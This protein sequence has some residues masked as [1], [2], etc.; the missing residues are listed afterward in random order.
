MLFVNRRKVWKPLKSYKVEVLGG[1]IPLLH[2]FQT[3]EGPDRKLVRLLS[4]VATFSKQILMSWL[5]PVP[6]ALSLIPSDQYGNYFYI[7]RSFQGFEVS[8]VKIFSLVF[9]KRPLKKKKRRLSMGIFNYFS[10]FLKFYF[11]LGC[12]GFLLQGVG[13]SLWWLLLL[14]STGSRHVGSVVVAQLPFTRD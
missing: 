5:P 7:L 8:K 14:R 11:I 3:S 10:Y 13:F 4:Q 9:K 6:P 1:A 2:S 12:T